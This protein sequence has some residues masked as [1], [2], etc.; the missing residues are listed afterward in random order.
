MAAGLPGK[1]AAAIEKSNRLMAEGIIQPEGFPEE[2]VKKK[3]YSI[4]SFN[5]KEEDKKMSENKTLENLMAAFAGEAQANRKYT[6]YAKKAE[7]DGKLNAAKLFRAAADAETLHALKH[8]E[9]AGKIGSTAD[10]LK[11]GIAGE[12]YEYKEMYPDFVK[13]AEAE[14]NKAALMSFT[15]AMKA[16]EVHAGLYK[17]ALDNIDQTEEV[18]Y[19]LCPLCGNIE[20]AV[21]ERCSICG[22]MG[23]KFIKY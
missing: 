15:F 10:N 3:N 11:D 19:Y 22:V 16:E 21:P 14:G 6:A 7:K 2:A 5:N 1:L 20:K 8:F 13:E 17:D 18:F 23:D 12:T 9:V 4:H